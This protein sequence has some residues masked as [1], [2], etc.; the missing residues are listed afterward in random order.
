M[1]KWVKG[2]QDR[3]V[4]LSKLTREAQ[5]NQIADELATRYRIQGRLTPSRT[6]DHPTAQRI[7]IALN[8]TRLTSQT[9]ECIR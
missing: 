6:M 2:H 3:L 7:S 5:L 9:D 1:M 8:S 4:S